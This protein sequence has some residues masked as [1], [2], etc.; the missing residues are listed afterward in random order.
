MARLVQELPVEIRAGETTVFLKIKSFASRSLSV[1]IV[2]LAAAS[3]L[4]TPARSDDVADFYKGKTISMA[5]GYPAGGGFDAAARLLIRHMPRHLPGNPSMIAKNVPG[6]ASLRAANYLFNVAP[7]DGTEIGIIGPSVPFGPLW[8]REGVSFEAMKFNWLG[9]LDRWVSIALVW[10]TAKVQTLE[11]A[12]K[13]EVVAGATGSGDMTVT[14]PRLLNAMLGTKFKIVPGY[15]GTPDLNLAIERGEVD[16]RL[17]WC[18]DCLKIDKPEWV[19]GKKVTI[20]LQFAFAKHPEL[21][22]VPLVMD[23]AKTEADRQLMRLSFANQEMAR[24]FLAPPG[25]PADR[26]AALRAAFE[27]TARDPAFL[28]EAKK[29]N[30]PINVATWQE[31]ESLLREVYATPQPVIDRAAKIIND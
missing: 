15:Q 22:D 25:V 23:L 11:G 10:H 20:L 14:Y 13:T 5:I 24:P 26:V 27:A 28:D 1:G 21:A 16:G 12:L 31:I 3:L 2:G 30:M 6:A 17:G 29:L 18:W 19:S 9:S 4:G 7:K 8:S